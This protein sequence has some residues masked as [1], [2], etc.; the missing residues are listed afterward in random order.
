MPI[1]NLVEVDSLQ[2]ATRFATEKSQ[3][4]EN[5]PN[6]MHENSTNAA[7]NNNHDRRRNPVT[8]ILRTLRELVGEESPYGTPTTCQ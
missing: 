5:V 2:N 7:R 1:A 4:S 3:S 6:A 8:P